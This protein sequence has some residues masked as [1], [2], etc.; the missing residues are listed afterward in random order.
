MGLSPYMHAQDAPIKSAM[1]S[2]PR[3]SS[4]GTQ[5]SPAQAIIS[6]VTRRLLWFSRSLST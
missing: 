3:T 2:A 1:G 4:S 6:A 5:H